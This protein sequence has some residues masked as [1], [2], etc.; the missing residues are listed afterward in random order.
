MRL[1]AVDKRTRDAFADLD[2]AGYNYMSGRYTVDGHRHPRRVIVGS[3]TSPTDTV[4]IW[5]EIEHLPQVIGDFTW[6]GWDYIGEAGY[7]VVRYDERR[8]LYAP[9]PGLLAGVGVIDITGHRQTQSYLNEIAWHRHR[10][11]CIAV[12]PVIHAGEKRTARAG[13]TDS[14]RSWSWEGCEGRIATV[15]VYADADNVDLLLDGVTVGS[16]AAGPRNGY[17]AQFSVP[18]RAGR[19]TAVAYDASGRE[20]G[21]DTLA[22]AGT[23]LCL[24]VR[25]ETL[26]LRADG[27]DL[28]YIPIELTDDAG[29]V[30][31]LA[32]RPVT[33]H[34]T[35]PGTLL[36]FGSAAPI[37]SEGFSSNRH[38]TH[39]GRALAVVRAGR[40]TGS[41]EVTVTA[42]GCEPTTVVITVVA[43]RPTGAHRAGEAHH[44]AP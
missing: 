20:I 33:V 26:E 35:G 15:E 7:G 27:N 16:E 8:Q 24:T 22:S 13:R 43:P 37:T 36:G 1:P 28:A 5:Q 10:G 14:I 25:P 19:L 9:Y 17:L 3:E 30:R 2:I 23:E 18:Y 42:E 32:D 39:W 31:P 12:Q 6:T 40:E 11:P 4:A 44:P 21:T 38:S 29:I 41:V 34:L